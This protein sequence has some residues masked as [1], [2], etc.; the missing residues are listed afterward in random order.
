M[1][2]RSSRIRGLGFQAFLGFRRSCGFQGSW[3]L[4]ASW[5][6]IP[7]SGFRVWDILERFAPSAS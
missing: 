7:A 5:L 1:W 6:R 3:K 4:R 2:G